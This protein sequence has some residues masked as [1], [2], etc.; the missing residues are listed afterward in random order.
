[1]Q[2]SLLSFSTSDTSMSENA[3]VNAAVL[4]GEAIGSDLDMVYLRVKGG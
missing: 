4:R 1:V 2:L 3:A